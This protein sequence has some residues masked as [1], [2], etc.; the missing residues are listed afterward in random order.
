MNKF[1]WGEPDDEP[2]PGWMDPKTYRKEGN[3]RG[4]YERKSLEK[5]AAE[6]LKKPP[7]PILLQDP[8]KKE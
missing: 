7:V 2:L 4:L 3:F 6:T 8:T 1:L 5:V